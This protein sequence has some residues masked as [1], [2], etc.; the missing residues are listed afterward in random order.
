MRS[1]R[2]LFFCLLYICLLAGSLRA[3]EKGEKWTVHNIEFEGNQEISDYRLKKV[4]LTKSANIFSHKPFHAHIFT[5]DLKSILQLYQHQGYLGA[6]IIDTLVFRDSLKY[7]VDIYITIE[8]GQRTLVEGIGIFGNAAFPDSLLLKQLNLKKGDPFRRK[9]VTDGAM[10]MLT[11]YANSGYLEVELEPDIRINAEIHRALIDFQIKEGPQFTIDDI[12]IEGNEVTQENVIRRELLFL[13]DDVVR[14][15]QLLDS[16]RQLYL[17]GLFQSV[18]TRTVPSASG[19]HAKK[20]VLVELKENESVELSVSLGYGTVEKARAKVGIY[21]SNIFGTARKFGI[22]PRISFIYRGVE[23]SYTEPWTF[24]TRWRT[25]VAAW[26]DYVEEPGYNLLR[27]GGRMTVGR[28][29]GRYTSIAVTFRNENSELS[30]VEVSPVPEEIDAFVRSLK[31]TPIYDSRD[32]MFNT[33]KGVYLE[34]SN[35]LAGSFLGGTDTFLRSIWRVKYFSPIKRNTVIGTALEFGWMDHFG[36]SDEIPLNE[37]FYA[38]GPNTMRGFEYRSVGPLDDDGTPVGGQFEVIW[39]VMEL[40]R[41]IYKM[42]GAAIFLDVGNVWGQVD[43]FK[44][45]D[46]RLSPG[47]G[48]RINTPIGIVRGDVGF[49]ID[50]RGNEDS[51]QFYFNVGQAF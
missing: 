19:A 50:P 18:F 9:R 34:W 13:N 41:A 23:A 33:N 32:N 40:R 38:G 6:Q 51:A 49:N 48:L 2:G 1:I 7:K 27:R 12:R 35:E 14:H 15:S 16:Q 22:T 39:N 45:D 31:L 44:W 47:F 42:V 4:M 3:A 28:N 36:G 37:R 46:I 21:F 43:D 5:D 20:D 25:D 24:G 29:L 26:I 10:A 8:E 11:S 30:D 17:T